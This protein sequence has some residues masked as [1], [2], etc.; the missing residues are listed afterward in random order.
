MPVPIRRIKLCRQVTRLD[1]ITRPLKSD[2]PLPRGYRRRSGESSTERSLCRRKRPFYSQDLIKIGFRC[3]KAPYQASRNDSR[4][5]KSKHCVKMSNYS[6][7][8][9]SITKTNACRKSGEAGLRLTGLS[10]QGCGRLSKSF[11]WYAV[12]S[13]LGPAVSARQRAPNRKLKLE[14]PLASL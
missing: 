11:L 7:G 1:L 8:D 14:N 10:G 4:I 13:V 12:G 5:N 6:L 2:Q 9:F 3:R